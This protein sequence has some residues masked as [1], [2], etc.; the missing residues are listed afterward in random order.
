MNR[1]HT[2]GALLALG[3]AGSPLRGSAQPK[4]PAKLPVVGLLYPNPTPPPSQRQENP[5]LA[6][7]KELGWIP[8]KTFRL[9]NASAE[10]REERL[11][12]VAEELVAKRVDVIWASGPE[13]A[14]AAARAT[15]DIPIV[16]FGVGFPV[17]L[18]LVDSLAR[19]GRN[20]TGLAYF[21]GAEL[22]T[23][24][25]ELLREI[26]PGAKHVAYLSVPSARRKVSGELFRGAEHVLDTAV[27]KLGLELRR[28]A[29]L[30]RE[31]LDAAFAAILASGANALM[32]TG[33]PLFVRDRQRIAEFAIANRLASAFS[34]WE[35]VEAGGLVSYG[36]DRIPAMAQSFTHVD[37]ILRGANP[38]E[39]PVELPGKYVLAA[40]VKTARLLGVSVPQSILLRADR[41]IE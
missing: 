6:R 41:V 40:N 20:V 3:A 13:A 23:K 31:E 12:S 11:P 30:R 38:A 25:L 33:H 15:G 22:E 37:R 29:P 35:F 8:G 39:L 36:V 9:E 16:F 1:R 21:A 28:Y 10:G 27:Q 34:A 17:E 19:P 5:V 26:V 18:G 32:A 4:K 24:Q 14:V 7:F 2:L